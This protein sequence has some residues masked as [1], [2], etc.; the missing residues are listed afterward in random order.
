MTGWRMPAET[1]PHEA[2]WMAWPSGSYTLGATAA[3]ADEARRTWAAVA[4]TIADHEPVH[5]LVPPTERTHAARLLAGDVVRHEALLDDAWYR[6]IGPTFVVGDDEGRPFLGA[7]NWVFNGWGR[8]EWATW[9]HD[10][11]ASSVATEATGAVRIDSPMVNEGGGIHTDGRGTFLVT[12]TVQLDPRRNPGWS[13]ADV[14]AELA[15][16][17][18]ARTVLWLPRGLTR[19][20][21]RYGTRG[22]VDIV[23][24]FTAPGRVL[25]HDQGDPAHPDHAVSREVAA[26][27]DGAHD[28]DGKPLEVTWIPAP[29][30][31]RDAHG[32]VDHSY[33]NH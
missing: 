26:V 24:T 27:L 4:N 33:V 16:T 8:Q 12:E 18:G 6:D 9:E 25:V 14:E 13:K 31:L 22:H 15:R 11:V 10:A 2:A 20:N 17:V 7:V 23:A 5:V 1:E 28:A 32:W 21:E 29:S 3:E 30:G 19:D